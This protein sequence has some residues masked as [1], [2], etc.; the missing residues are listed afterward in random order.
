MSAWLLICLSVWNNSAPTGQIFVKRDCIK[1]NEN[2]SKIEFH[3]SVIRI[4]VA[5]H[6]VNAVFIIS[7]SNLLRMRTVSDSW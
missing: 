2:L 3:Y 4:A 1:F 6:D 7:C 5:L